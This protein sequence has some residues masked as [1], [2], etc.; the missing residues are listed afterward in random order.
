MNDKSINLLDQY[1]LTIKSISKGRGTLICDTDIGKCVFKEYKGKPEKLELIKRLQDRFTDTL[2]T[3]TIIPTKENK[4][5]VKDQSENAVDKSAYIL[6]IHIEGKECSYRSEDDLVKA[7]SAMARMHLR[8]MTPTIYSGDESVSPMPVNFYPDEMKRHTA[9][10]KRVYNY[11]KKRTAKTDFERTLINEYSYFLQ[12]AVDVT[13]KAADE[14]QAEYEAYVRCNHLYCH[15]DY[16]YHNVI[17]G[18]AG[19]TPYTAIINMEHL[20]AAPGI[21]DFYLFFRKVCQ[22]YDWSIDIAATMLDA[23][24]NRRAIPPIELRSLRLMLEYPEKFWK[25]ADHYYNSKKSWM[26]SNNLEKLERLLKQEKNKEKL[27]NK[28]FY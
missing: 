26:P 13:S 2:R 4:L 3:D 20:L 17:F 12:K 7:C 16:Q 18:S 21:N 19:D 9:E 24:Q 22:K 25:I 14:S 11:L 1:D 23:Y 28:L 5:Y 15:G 6:S 8:F 10:C 27:I